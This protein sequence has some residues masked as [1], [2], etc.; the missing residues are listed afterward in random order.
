MK[1]TTLLPDGNGNWAVGEVKENTIKEDGKNRTSEERVSHAD[2]DGKDFQRFHA[3]LAKRQ[4]PP[5]EKKAI[6]SK[7]IL[8]MLLD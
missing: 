7:H 5:P 1:K 8:W 2:S 3:P 4:K 6:P